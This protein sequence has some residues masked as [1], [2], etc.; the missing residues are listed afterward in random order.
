MASAAIQSQPGGYRNENLP[1][2]SPI[3]KLGH[4]S[5]DETDNED[6]DIHKHVV[7]RKCKQAKSQPWKAHSGPQEDG[8]SDT[9]EG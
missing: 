9:E 7:A 2:E 4:S 3:S 1:I 8:D 5:D 6:T